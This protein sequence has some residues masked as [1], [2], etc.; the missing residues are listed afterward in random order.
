M[1]ATIE[2]DFTQDWTGS[3]AAPTRWDELPTDGS[4]AW[5]GL[6]LLLASSIVA[7]RGLCWAA[8]TL[9]RLAH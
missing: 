4:H 2:S 6:I 7:I 9:I 5:L 1:S 3:R 8:A